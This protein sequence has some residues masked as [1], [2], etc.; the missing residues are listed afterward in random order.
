MRKLLRFISCFAVTFLGCVQCVLAGLPLEMPALHSD[1]NT[2]AYDLLP[3]ATQPSRQAIDAAI[4]EATS[5]HRII[6][7]GNSGLNIPEA[8]KEITSLPVIFRVTVQQHAYDITV[9]SMSFLPDGAS[10]VVGCRFNLPGSQTNLYFGSSDIAVSGKSGFRGD[11]PILGESNDGISE[12]SIPGFNDKLLMGLAADSKMQFS[13]GAF[14]GFSLSGFVKAKNL[15]QTE[16][17]DGSLSEDSMPLL[18][19]EKQMATDW[20]DLFISAKVSSGFHAT[21]YPDLGFHFGNNDLATIDLSNL[22]NPENLPSCAQVSAESWQGV[23][24]P[25][26]KFRLPRF[27]KLRS[28][29]ALAMAPGK[30]LFMDASGLLGEAV[31]ENVYTLKEGYTDEINKYDMSLSKL[32]A[33]FSCNGQVTVSMLGE[34]GLPWCG[35]T[36]SKSDLPLLRYSFRYANERYE[37][38]VKDTEKGSF[39]SNKYAL[40][41]GSELIF[42]VK[43]SELLVNAILAEK[44]A[45]ATSVYSQSICKDFPV[46]LTASGC[47]GKQLI[48]NTGAAGASLTVKPLVSTAYTVKCQDNYCIAAV[49]DSLKI[50]VYESLPKPTLT[51]ERDA[52]CENENTIL[53]TDQCVGQIEW[54][55]PGSGSFVQTGNDGRSQH[56]NFQVNQSTSYAYAVRCNLNGCLSPET[57]KNV[58]VH[59]E[60]NAPLLLSD[61]VN[62]TVDRNNRVNLSGNCATGERLIWQDLPATSLALTNTSTYHAICRNDATGCQ[63]AVASI[64]VN[65]LYFPPGAPSNL[66][67]AGATASSLNLH[68][69]DNANNEDGFIILRSTSSSFSNAQQVGTVAANT[70]SFHDSNLSEAVT[71]YYQ[72][73]AHNRYDRGYSDWAS[74]ATAI[75]L[76]AA[77]PQLRADKNSV[78]PGE[79][80]VVYADGCDGTVTWSTGATGNSIWTGAGEYWAV[81]KKDGFRDSEAATIRIDQENTPTE[82][83]QASRPTMRAD[84]NPVRPGENTVVYAD[85]CDGTVTWS[86][87]ATGNTIWTGAGEYWAVCKK[88]GFRDSEAATI[89][90]DQD[91]TPAELPQA[92]RPTMRADRNPVKQGENTVVYADGCDGTVTWSTGA[93]G[94]SIWTGAGEYWAVCK[95]DGFRES[96]AATIRIDQDNTPAELPQASRPTMRADRNPVRPGENTVVYADGCDGTVTWST[97]ATGNSIW[98][99]AGEYW[100]VCKKEG[101]RDSEAA[102]IRIDQDNTPTE[103]PQ[104]SR[105]TMRADRNPVRPG[106]NTVVYAD[107]CDGTV[108]WSTS[109]TGNS[110]WTGAG[111]YWAVCKKEGFRDSEAATIRIDQDNTPTELP[112]ASRPTMRADRNPVRPG[113]NTVVYADGC[114]GTV[115]WSTSATGN[116]IWTGAGEYWAVCKKEGFRDSEAAT[117]RIDQENAPAEL[118]QASRPTMR[119]DRNPVKQGENTV[120]YADGCDGT[121]TWSTGAT[122]NSIWTGAGEYWAVCKKDGFRDSEAATIRIDQENT[123]TEL[124]QAS[125]PTM[126]ADKNPVKPGENTVVYADGC[127]GTVTWSTG[128]TGNSIW[129]GA[130]EYWA[131]CKKEGFR[132][133]EAAT[134]RI[135]QD[136]TPTELPQASR[137]T[138]RADRNPVKQGENTV[139]YADGCDGTVTWSTGATGNSIWTGAGEYWA[140]CKKDGFRDSES[141]TIRIDQDNTPTELPQASRPTMRADRNPVKQ[142]ENTVVY[143]DGCDGTVTWSTGATGN[144]IWT[145]A[146]E[147][148]AVCKKDG[149]RDSE[150]ATIRIDQEN[151]PCNPPSTPYIAVDDITHNLSELTFLTAKGCADGVIV[152]SDGTVGNRLLVSHGGDYTATCTVRN[153]CGQAEA[154][155]TGHVTTITPCLLMRPVFS[156][157][158]SSVFGGSFDMKEG[159]TVH[160]D[161]SCL[162]G[163]L[164][165][166]ESG[167]G[168]YTPRENF[169][170]NATCT[171]GD[172]CSK[173]ASLS[174]HVEKCNLAAPVITGPS[175][176]WKGEQFTLNAS[177]CSEG[178]TFRWSPAGSS[179]ASNTRIGAGFSEITTAINSDTRFS[180]T[181]EWLSCVSAPGYHTVNVLTIPPQPEPPTDPCAGKDTSP[182]WMTVPGGCAQ[183]AG[184]LS[185]DEN[186]CSPTYNQTRCCKEYMFY[187]SRSREIKAQITYM[188]CNGDEKTISI[189][190]GSSIKVMAMEGHAECVGCSNAAN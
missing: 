8:M 136:N 19:F 76:K 113:E 28:G 122:G 181:C 52:F 63:G 98:T 51:A 126:R 116:T 184:V 107:G 137:P 20:K 105:P 23:A 171:S 156:I 132:D 87:G 68:W 157:N 88:E 4:T 163:Q 83:P 47:T 17:A 115:T 18:T 77:T 180:V 159:A 149:F 21:N 174:I 134:I 139:V 48:W 49:S 40:S 152:W 44:P 5:Q 69:Q 185:R 103:L 161:A 31:A 168:D 94:N 189:N 177:G 84:K 82:L 50:T 182:R 58:T 183:G 111:E 93:T 46:T 79:N 67:F 128:A 43:N 173:S 29:A 81:C 155:A 71:Y 35:T 172:G 117:I 179:A 15:V 133:S 55:T 57:V 70:T 124:P 162:M 86:T 56:V 151:A 187:G 176:V 130:G 165:W 99:G 80:T 12:F 41:T 146:G 26:F 90:I 188:D 13:C 10:L 89:R 24:F 32:T 53:L 144:S 2:A 27:F 75:M 39:S 166:S 30:N 91:N 186:N 138:M 62:N 16:T 167:S 150:A 64:T 148:W 101:F 60:P 147:Y 123:P 59:P 104:A 37:I 72:V 140:V 127:D 164:Q 129:T 97:S 169:T 96:E 3:V 118:P 100:A 142:G 38:F 135:D 190:S 143:A 106:E 125:R 121:V 109:A 120:V 73:I 7:V 14:Q 66:A 65:V 141:A 33:T 178:S 170:F 25:S 92:S 42:S 154:S 22:R 11:L 175:E 45:V 131:V 1:R 74:A 61:A 110:I 6:K 34:I 119:A 158:G 9:M 95:K 54:K 85:G 153:E 36:P 145:G 112:Q 114:D 78:K 102:T 160:V 108:T